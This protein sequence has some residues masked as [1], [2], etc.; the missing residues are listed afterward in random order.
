MTP[1]ALLRHAPSDWNEAGLIQGQA[2]RPLSPAGRAMALAWRLPAAL[3]GRAWATSPLQRA[4][5]TARLL[6]HGDACVE[7]RLIEM[8][9]GA[10]T[11]RCLGGLRR[12]LGA[13]MA[14][15]EARGLDM[16]PEGGETPREVVARLA[17]WLDEVAAA[18][19]PMVAVAHRGTQRAALALAAGWDYLGRPPLRPGRDGILMLEVGTGR[20]RLAEPALLS[21]AAP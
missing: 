12:E 9:W 11:G 8:N 6:G 13:T 10:W 16:R 5:E 4:R 3:E 7:P 1:V 21:L 15:N 14:A 17:A 20:V 18:G 2:D 19:Q